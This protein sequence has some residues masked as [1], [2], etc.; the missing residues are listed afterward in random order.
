VLEAAEKKVMTTDSFRPTAE[1]IQKIQDKYDI[2]TEMG[3]E[4]FTTLL[5]GKHLTFLTRYAKYLLDYLNSTTI[6]PSQ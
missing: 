3:Y 4:E 2:A 1:N 6:L 5:D